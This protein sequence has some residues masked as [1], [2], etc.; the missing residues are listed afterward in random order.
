[1]AITLEKRV[2]HFVTLTTTFVVA[3]MGLNLVSSLYRYSNF[4][5]ENVIEEAVEFD[6]HPSNRKPPTEGDGGSRWVPENKSNSN[7]KL[8]TY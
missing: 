2:Y 6:F 4:T 8:G 3:S 5:P 1:M 7:S